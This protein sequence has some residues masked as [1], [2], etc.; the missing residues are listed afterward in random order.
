MRSV[1]LTVQLL[2]AGLAVFLLK[3]D[4]RMTPLIAV[5][6]ALAIFNAWTWIRSRNPRPAGDIELLLQL[7][8]DSVALSVSLY[9]Y[10][11]ATNP[12]VSFYLLSIAVGAALLPW[13]YAV[14][15]PIFSIV[16]Y[17]L[18]TK[19]YVPLHIMDLD[20]AIS[21]HLAGMWANFAVSAT[22]I[23]WFVVRLSRQLRQRD[24]LLAAARELQLQNERFVA[25]G[26]QAANAAHEMG[27]PLSTVAIIAG[28][29]HR[30]CASNESLIAYRDDLNT[31]ETQ[32][33]LCKV[34]LDRMGHAAVSS[35][36]TVFL[37]SWLEQ[38]IQ[39]WRLRYPS[40]RLSI[41]LPPEEMQSQVN[42]AAVIG[43]V[44]TTLLDNCAQAFA[45]NDGLIHLS[46]RSDA[47]C[48]M[49]EVADNGPGIASD[50][51][52]RLGHEPVR[53]AYNGQGIG[54]L[55][56]FASA[57]Q[58]GATIVFSRQ[59]SNGTVATLTIPKAVTK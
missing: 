57:R 12:F 11:G 16:C 54:L 40:V 37:V 6:L 20:L 58:I 10:G 8:V 7:V 26:M 36:G 22:L 33:S 3:I 28:E 43:Q 38:F 4:I 52:D 17:S 23:T 14:T 18:L 39:T 55:L 13:R 46:L 48:T 27:S 24:S 25:L 50:L 5:I 56:A 49:I 47:R 31:I 51:L 59:R 35:G 9:F 15:L 41:V 53:S 2:V 34:A 42:D 21:Y 32:I 30:E 44:L 1:A 45:S 29:L 19:F